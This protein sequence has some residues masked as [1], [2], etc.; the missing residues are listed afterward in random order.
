MSGPNCSMFRTVHPRRAV[1]ASPAVHEIR[2]VHAAPT[3]RRFR[4]LTG[5]RRSSGHRL[6]R[7]LG[8]T[9]AVMLGSAA[10]AVAMPPVATPASAAGTWTL[11]LGT[12]TG[13]T[14]T[15]F[16][17]NGT[18]TSDGNAGFVEVLYAPAGTPLTPSSPS[19]GLVIFNAGE[20][21]PQPVSIPID[22]LTPNTSY[23]YILEATEDDN[24]ATFFSIAGIGTTT[25][26]PTGPGTPID[27]PAVPSS[28]G[29]FGQCSGDGACVNDM[30]GVRA[31]QEQ[32]PPLTLPSNWGTLTGPEQMFVWTNLERTSRG[33]VAIPDLVTTFNSAVAAGL[34]DDADPSLSNLPGNSASIWAALLAL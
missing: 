3:R 2:R 22:Q 7:R 33:E 9:A 32:L 13:I 6:V 10:M 23:A 8:V 25:T 26:T 30:N 16:V 19:A 17:A 34:A 21:G 18:V 15:G 11:T 28:N 5:Q 14:T 29:I 12:P 24:A 27:P 20:T 31:A 4:S 1:H